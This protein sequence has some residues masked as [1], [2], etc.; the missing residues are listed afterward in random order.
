[1]DRVAAAAAVGHFS[2]FSSFIV[3]SVCGFVKPEKQ[4]FPAPETVGKL[5]RRLAAR[6]FFTSGKRKNFMSPSCAVS[7]DDSALSRETDD[8]RR[9]T[10]P[11]RPSFGAVHRMP[12]DARRIFGRLCGI[13]IRLCVLIR[14]HDPANRRMA[15]DP[16]LSFFRL[17]IIRAQSFHTNQKSEKGVSVCSKPNAAGCPRSARPW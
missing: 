15:Q 5:C 11:Y 9:G 17:C 1:M 3:P 12:S 4:R 13:G 10:K 8:A 7:F 16:R 6:H 2:R 14:L